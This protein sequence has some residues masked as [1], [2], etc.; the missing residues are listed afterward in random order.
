MIRRRTPPLALAVL[1]LAGLA[2]VAQ[3]QL[4]DNLGALSGD[5]AKGYLSPLPKALS[6]TLNSAVFQTGHVPK[7]TFNLSVGVRLMGVGFSDDTRSYTPTA[8]PGFTPT[9][10]VQAPTVIGNTQAVSQ[11]GQGGTTLYHPGGF[12]ISEFAVA[13]PQLSIGSVFGTRAVIRWISLDLGDSDLGKFEYVGYGAQHS[14][15]QYFP[16]LPV[17]LAAGFFA[18]SFELGDNLIKTDALM[19]NVTGSKRFGMLEPYAAVG[20]DTFDMDVSYESTSTPGN[21]IAIKFDKESNAHLTLGIQ[22]LLGFT[23]LSAEVNV[24][25]ETGAAIGLA[26][27][28]Y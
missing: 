27:G 28:R 9:E 22:A 2:S 3:A 7:N 24:A 4:S 1:A 13:V 15:S 5:N 26:L 20:Y 8:P 6:A 18:Q 23:R 14:V 17:D 10:T 11:N 19:F 21:N 25:A 16:G 12:D